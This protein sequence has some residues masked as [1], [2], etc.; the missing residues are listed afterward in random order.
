MRAAADSREAEAPARR[1]EYELL[2]SVQELE[3]L[4]T[5]AHVAPVGI[6]RADELG[7][8]TYVNDRWTE[9]TGYSS[10]DAVGESWELAVHPEDVSMVRQKW[11]GALSART[12]FSVEHR[13]R[14]P[15]GRFVWV[16][17]DIVREVDGRGCVTGYT[18][19]STDIT[20]LHA[21][22]EEL[23][24]S[25]AALEVRM[26]DRAKELQRMGLI[27]AASDD[28]IISSD[29]HGKIVTWNPGAERIFGYT[30]AEMLGQE[31]STLTPEEK[32]AEADE[33]KARVRD[34]EEIH[35]LET[36]RVAKSGELLDV[37]ISIFPLR[38]EQG[39]VTGTCGIVRDI[40]ERK[41]AERRLQLLSWRLL[42]VQDEERR[43]IARDLHDSTAQALAALCMNL[44]A[45][46]R[47]NPPLTPE[48]QQQVLADSVS[49]AEQATS[50][51]RTTSYLL[52]PPLLDERGLP[53]ALAWLISGFSERSGV[54][55][56]VEISPELQRL[57][58]EVETALFRVVQE[59]L[60]NV[61][62]HSGSKTVEVRLSSSETELML[63]VRDH[64]GG[65]PVD[66]G[67]ALGVG[68]AGMRERLLQLGGTLVIESNDPGAAV[69]ARLPIR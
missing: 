55:V 19:M 36:V 47:Q 60:H 18:G 35:H 69:I 32:R 62:R 14:Q 38:D 13:Y 40:T 49:L 54:K 44:S 59:S 25:H 51:L 9:L 39:V 37:S 53:A 6:F 68:I 10:S 22:R 29:E 50:E 27:V 12:P 3:W 66:Q 31:T 21:I 46:A 30:A 56:K 33:M 8:C 42:R 23:Q 43:R 7:H 28:A 61:H 20:E 48:R 34:G 64:G 24:H 26:R 11:R 17:S 5:L 45:L 52:H 16:L 63:E 1:R 67:E 4:R 57:P 58:I 2:R 65:L 41:R 15:N